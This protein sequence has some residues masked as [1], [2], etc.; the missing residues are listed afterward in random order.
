V[1][2]IE[3]NLNYIN[4]AMAGIQNVSFEN[5][6]LRNSNFQ[7]N[8]PKNLIFKEADLTGAQFFN[9]SLKDIDLSDSRVEGLVISTQDI[10]GAIINQFQAVDLIGL[11]GVKI[12]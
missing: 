9:T 3:G 1:S 5:T 6:V 7:E 4:L 2:F 12:K 10:K 11:L 8:K